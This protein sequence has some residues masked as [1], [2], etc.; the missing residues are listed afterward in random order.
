MQKNIR[1]H[2]RFLLFL[3]EQRIIIAK[4][5]ARKRNIFAYMYVI[6][7]KE[8]K[9]SKKDTEKYFPINN[10]VAINI[11]TIRQI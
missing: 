1:E 2:N 6:S 7:Q 11:P 10:F 5:A 9:N 4:N 8:E 3:L